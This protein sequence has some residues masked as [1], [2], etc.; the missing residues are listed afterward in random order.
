VSFL[1]D[2]FEWFADPARW[3]GPSGIPNR[4]T[5]HLWMS[6]VALLLAMLA[7]LP[8]AVWL[9]HRRRFGMLAMNIS[10][11]GRA[12][13]S[14]AILVFGAQLWGIGERFGI[15]KAALLALFA[16]ALPP[17]VTNAYVGMAEVDDAIRDSARGMGMTGGQR[18]LRVELPVAV[19]M[20][21]NGIRIA[22]L[23]VIATAGLAAVVASGGLGRYIVDG[24]AVQDYIQ[25]FAGAV[26]VAGLALAVEAALAAGQRALTPRGIRLVRSRRARLRGSPT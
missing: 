6:A 16:L 14:F 9:G 17:I 26:L 5:E 25:V 19:P 24:F 18:L 3:S 8:V 20:I 7:G 2:V 1:A 4:L 22:M 13:P 15:S 11:I 23:Q 21:M 12:I 10:N